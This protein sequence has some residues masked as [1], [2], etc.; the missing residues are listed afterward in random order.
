MKKFM[1]F[2]FVVLVGWSLGAQNLSDEEFL[3]VLRKGEGYSPQFKATMLFEVNN[4]GGAPSVAELTLYENSGKSIAVFL[5][6]A[7][8]K[9]KVI[10]QLDSKYW[11]YFPKAKRSTVLSPLANMVGNASNGDVLR[12]PQAELYDISLLEDT[13]K[14]GNR[15]VQFLASSRKA[16][17]GKIIAYYENDKI[18]ATELY[19]RSGVLLK[20]TESLDHIKNTGGFGWMPVKTRI[21][22]GK[23]PEIFTIITFSNVVIMKDMN[24]SWFN[25]NNLGRVR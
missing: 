3:R 5:S 21:V 4:P 24:Q 11:L 7:R 1:A 17:Y 10:L 23:N 18:L 12:P 8:D 2:V 15:T 13:P 22:D 20:T 19:S 6:P 9:G 16:P 25:P 14:K